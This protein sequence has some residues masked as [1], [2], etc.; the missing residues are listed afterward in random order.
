MVTGGGSPFEAVS[1]ERLRRR[2]T[3]KW[4]LYGPDVLAAWVA[5]MDVDVAP[6]VKAALLDAVER[7]DFGYVEADLSELTGAASD[8]FASTYGWDVPAHRVFPVA[9]VLAGVR[10]ALDTFVAPGAPVV[11]PTPAYPPL[12]DVVELSGRPVVAVPMVDEPAGAREVGPAPGTDRVQ[13]RPDARG[14]G[15]RHPGPGGSDP[16]GRDRGA[17][18]SARPDDG[19]RGGGDP[20][21]VG[22]PPPGRPA[23]DLE[24]IDAAL[25]AG[26]GAVLLTNPHNP[27]GRVFGAAELGALAEVVDRHGARVVADEVHGPLTYPGHPFLPYASVGEAAA[28]HTVTVT[29]ASKAWNLAGLKCAQVVT[30]RDD[31]RRWRAVPLFA[32]PGPTPLGI[33]AST[34]A[35]RDARDWLAALVVHLDANRR[36]LADLV[37]EELPGVRLLPPEGT[38]LAWLDCAAL[39]LDDP[40]RFFLDEARVAVSDGPAYGGPGGGYVQH[41]RLNFA[42]STALLDRIVGA[43]GAALR[44]R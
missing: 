38:F 13:R 14:D 4:T 29:S 24:R 36:R 39:G 32:V 6:A 11:V 37:A 26:A 35:D 10:G 3:V 25:A 23:L 9:D 28:A 41:V 22:D 34:A 21:S 44:R 27:T 7:E 40:A 5:E 30:G 19:H 16:A 43:M 1:L 33:A 2:R 31:A 12:F 18:P 17:R 20:P 15:D 8:F 42:T